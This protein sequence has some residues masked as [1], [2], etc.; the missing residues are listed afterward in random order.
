[1][2]SRLIASV[3][4][5]MLNMD[6]EFSFNFRQWHEAFLN[7]NTRRFKIQ[8]SDMGPT[9]TTTT[10]RGL[11]VTLFELLTRTLFERH[12][13]KSV[14]W[15]YLLVLS[16]LFVSVVLSTIMDKS[17]RTL[18]RFWGVFQFTQVQPLPSPHKQACIQN[19]FATL[20]RVGGGRTAR[21]FRKGC[22]VLR[23]N[24]EKISPVKSEKCS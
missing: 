20:Y 16:W 19:F 15:H 1:M 17:L 23:G 8:T 22:T 5:K 24:Q 13:V 4:L 3:S 9:P 12:C 10:W 14:Q 7:T 2:S 11:L 21:K 6:K 18:L